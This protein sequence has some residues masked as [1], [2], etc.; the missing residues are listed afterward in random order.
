MGKDVYLADVSQEL[1]STRRILERVPEEHWNWRP[2]E[3]SMGLGELA[4]HVTNLLFWQVTILRDSAFD[5]AA[6]PQRRE[7]QSG[8]QAL[9]EEYDRRV[10]E[11]QDALSATDEEALGEEWTLRRGDHVMFR[12]PR[13]VALRSFG[14]SHMIHHRGQLGVYLRLLDVPVPGI[15]GPTADEPVS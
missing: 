1:A 3:K 15:Y 5:L 7:A 10:G 2:H 14:L 8:P 9:L 12:V 11:L 13:A 6:G 4:T